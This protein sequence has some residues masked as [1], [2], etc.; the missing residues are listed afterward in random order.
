MLSNFIF[1]SIS[2]TFAARFVSARAAEQA[3]A[4]ALF[5]AAE[6][7]ARARLAALFGDPRCGFCASA[8]F[9]GLKAEHAALKSKVEVA[10][11]LEALEHTS[12]DATA[13]EHESHDEAGDD[14]D[15]EKKK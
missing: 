15:E 14:S 9:A 1:F 3:P 12:L 13:T 4:R 2:A 10:S 11:H 6:D 5:D 8:H 7:D